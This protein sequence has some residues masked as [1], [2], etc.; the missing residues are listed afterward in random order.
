MATATKEKK[1]TR[2]VQAGKVKKGHLMAFLYY[3]HVDHTRNSDSLRVKD[4]DRKID[5]DVNGRELIESAYSADQFHTTKRTTKTKI[6][7]ILVSSFNRPFTVCFEKTDGSE[8]VLR[9]RLIQPEPLMGRSMV[10]DL[11]V[12]GRRLRQVDHRTIKYLI[13]DGIKYTVSKK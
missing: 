6:A 1:E 7:E 5:F 2:R 11:D 10:D 12:D 8:R 9:G 4:V 3:A 13:V